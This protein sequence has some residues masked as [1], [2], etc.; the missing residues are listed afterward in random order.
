MSL[1]ESHSTLAIACQRLLQ[2]QNNSRASTKDSWNAAG[3]QTSSACNGTVLQYAAQFANER[4]VFPPVALASYLADCKNITKYC[5]LESA[6][7][8][9]T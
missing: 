9:M 3:Q 1:A 4:F 7:L 5:S 8:E 2:H 6:A